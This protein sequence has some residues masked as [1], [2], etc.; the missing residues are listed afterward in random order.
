MSLTQIS[1]TIHLIFRLS[2]APSLRWRASRMPVRHNTL[3]L[4]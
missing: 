4:R 3:E 2:N 1:D